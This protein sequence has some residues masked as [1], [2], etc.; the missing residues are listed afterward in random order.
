MSRHAIPVVKHAVLFSAALLITTP[1]V[2]AGDRV[3]AGRQTTTSQTAPAV[4]TKAAAQSIVVSVVTT[5]AAQP[6]N[7]RAFVDLRGPDGQV[8]RFPVEG[9]PEAIEVRRLVLRPG[10]TLTIHLALAK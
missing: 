8:R 3:H 6:A 4:V 7:E 5:K 9:G 1:S 2:L 10:Q